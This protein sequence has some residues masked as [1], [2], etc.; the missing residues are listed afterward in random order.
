MS[1]VNK[2]L[3]AASG[4]LAAVLAAYCGTL[5]RD[6]VDGVVQNEPRSVQKLVASRDDTE[7]PE[8]DYFDDLTRLVRREFVEPVDDV[9]KLAVGAVRGMVAS[10]GDPKSIFM[11]PKEFKVYLG[12]RQ[13]RYEGIGAE[14]ELQMPGTPGHDAQAALQPTDADPEVAVS[15]PRIPKLTVMA[16]TPGGPAQKAGVRPGD[17]VVEVDGH[18]VVSEDMLKKFREAEKEFREHK[19]DASRINAIRESMHEMSERALLPL[20]AWDRLSEDA[21]GSTEV[22]WG[23]DGAERSTRIA[24]AVS[25]MPAFGVHDGHITLPFTKGA[26]AELKKAIEGKSQITIDLRDNV[27]GDQGAMEEC[28]AVLAPKGEYGRMFSVHYPRGLAITVKNGNPHPPAINL[29][30]DRTTRGAAEIFA[31]ALN[32]SHVARLVGSDTGGDRAMEQIVELPDGSGY[33]L[34][35]GSY[36]PVVVETAG[37]AKKGGA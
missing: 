19:I 10:L 27:L 4:V 12:E 18:W 20:R 6:R 23:R 7:I 30:V 2:S 9:Q 8:G 21:S 1:E 15:A 35:I 3:L 11:D 31:L 32:S 25:S 13:G 24:K 36:R 16:V 33:T 17:T 5:S 37:V 28:L 29:L 34:R 22:V 26:S 14:L